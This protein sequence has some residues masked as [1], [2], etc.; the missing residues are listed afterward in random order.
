[1]IGGFEKYEDFNYVIL[2][3][4]KTYLIHIS[5]YIV[6]VHSSPYLCVY[7]DDRIICYPGVDDVIGEPRAA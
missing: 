7:G 3:L 1:M 6:F 2:G 4:G 5:V